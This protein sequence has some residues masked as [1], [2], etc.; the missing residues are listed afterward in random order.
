MKMINIMFSF[1]LIKI[2]LFSLKA[3]APLHTIYSINA[4]ENNNYKTNLIFFF[5][6]KSFS[7]YYDPFLAAAAAQA[8]PNYRLQVC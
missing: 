6:M 2:Y 8:D 5:Q 3:S 4:N 1:L 7:V